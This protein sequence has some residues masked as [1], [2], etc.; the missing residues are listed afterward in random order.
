MVAVAVPDV[1]RHE[2][3]FVWI[4]GG[5]NGPDTGPAPPNDDLIGLIVTVAVQT[6]AIGSYVLQVPNQPMTFTVRTA[7]VCSLV[8]E[9]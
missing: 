5:S 8:C 6:G 4:E 7:H 3:A 9:T 2:A 1:I